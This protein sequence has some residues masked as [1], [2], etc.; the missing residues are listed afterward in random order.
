MPLV[1][2]HAHALTK[3]LPKAQ[4]PHAGDSTQARGKVLQP[5]TVDGP[6]LR[7]RAAGNKAG[8]Q[9]VTWRN[10]LPSRMRHHEPSSSLVMPHGNEVEVPRPHSD[11][12]AAR[13]PAAVDGKPAQP[14]GEILRLAQTVTKPHNFFARLSPRPVGANAPWPRAVGT[15]MPRPGAIGLNVLRPGV[16]GH[17]DRGLAW[18]AIRTMAGTYDLLLGHTTTR[19]DTAASYR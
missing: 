4:R 14:H 2:R 15:E 13:L 16:V 10:L 3:E 17:N 7:H 5:C 9:A 8:N 19:Q 18:V 1:T 6:T 12:G 11:N